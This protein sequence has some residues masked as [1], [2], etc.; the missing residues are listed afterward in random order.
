M[1]LFPMPCMLLVLFG[2]LCAGCTGNSPAGPGLTVTPIPTAAAA[3][4]TTAVT[5]T[6]PNLSLG[7]QYLYKSYPFS[8]Q[9]IKFNEQIRIDDPSWAIVYTVLPLSDNPQNCWFAMTVTNLDTQKNQTFTWTYIND[10][11]QQYPMYTPGLYQFA[12]TGT[13]V[14]VDLTMAK[15]LP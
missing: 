5:M 13:L 9:N 15:R 12:M 1:K 10:T 11:Y 3:V 4:T 8:G 2:V 14:K 6:Q 7:A